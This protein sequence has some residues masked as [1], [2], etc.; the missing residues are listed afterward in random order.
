M[1][2]QS[3]PEEHS[4]LRRLFLV[5]FSVTA[6]AA[7]ARLHL[8]VPGSPVPQSAQTLAVLLVGLGLGARDGTAALFVYLMAGGLG[9]PVF[10]DGAAGWA[11]VVGPTSGYLFAFVITAGMVGWLAQRGYLR[12]FASALTAM[13]GGHVLILSLGWVRLAATIGLEPGYRQGFAP[14]LLGGLA[15]SVVAAVIAVLWVRYLGLQDE[16]AVT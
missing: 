10:S 16:S 6:V 14:F 3:S 15:K 2:D 12:R 8:P 5:L 1:V 13:I 4:V 11:H 7:S 9:A